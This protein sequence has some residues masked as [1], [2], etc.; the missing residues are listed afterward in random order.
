M[1]NADE[2]AGRFELRSLQKFGRVKPILAITEAQI[3]DKLTLRN[4]FRNHR[5]Y[6]Q[7]QNESIAPIK[8]YK[9]VLVLL[10]YYLIVGTCNGVSKCKFVMWLVKILCTGN[11]KG[12]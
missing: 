1:Y 5:R 9:I 4:A 6:I 7:P 2:C 10:L 11:G 12:R 8:L 3:L